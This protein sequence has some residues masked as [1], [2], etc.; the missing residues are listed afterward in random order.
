MRISKLRLTIAAVVGAV[1]FTGAGAG[2]AFAF[3]P[4]M[5]SARGDLQAAQTELQ[6]ASP[7]KAGHRVNAM[8]LV[9]QAINEVNAGIQAGAQ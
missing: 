2:V 3:Q 7:D 1:V 8:N 9:Q 4:H 5:V 6:Q